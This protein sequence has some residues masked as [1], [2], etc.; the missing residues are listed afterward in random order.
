[1]ATKKTESENALPE[2]IRDSQPEHFSAET[3]SGLRSFE[4]ALAL[5][6]E[7]FGTVDVADEA[8]GDGFALLDKDEKAKLVGIPL[9]FLEWTFNASDKYEGSV[10]VSAR[11]VANV[12]NGV[13]AKYI[14][15]DGSTGLAKQLEEYTNKTGRR[16]GLAVR[17][18]L[19]R[20]DY[21]KVINGKKT[22]AT[23]FYLDTSA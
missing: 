4:D 10:F 6:Q 14:I 18:G 12:G 3:L 15:N 5:A 20:S 1:M 9:V 23:T 19:R 11:V 22:E 2:I 16:G 17:K 13:M 21:V 8:I 7:T